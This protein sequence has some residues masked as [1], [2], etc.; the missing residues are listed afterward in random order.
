MQE[1]L[2]WTKKKKSDETWYVAPLSSIQEWDKI[3]LAGEELGRPAALAK[4]SVFLNVGLDRCTSDA[5][6]CLHWST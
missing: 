3:E 1:V 4:T 6:N 2:K 5:A